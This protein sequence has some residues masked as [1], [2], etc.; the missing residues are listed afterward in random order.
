[1]KHTLSRPI[2]TL[3]LAM[4]I[5]IAMVALPGSA[6]AQRKLAKAQLFSLLLH[7]T[8]SGV[9]AICVPESVVA[10]HLAHGD[11]DM[12]LNCTPPGELPE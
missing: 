12:G 4:A 2:S 9:K 3:L 10:E 1:M 7:W 11:V 6:Q 8:G 5:T